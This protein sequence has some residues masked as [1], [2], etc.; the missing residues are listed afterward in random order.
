MR[1]IFKCTHYFAEGERKNWAML[2]MENTPPHFH[3]WRVFAPLRAPGASRALPD[4]QTQIQVALESEECPHCLG[5]WDPTYPD[6][7]EVIYAKE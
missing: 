3:E 6:T 1:Y 4:L 2:H 5:A 7:V